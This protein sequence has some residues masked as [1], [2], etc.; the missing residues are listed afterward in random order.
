MNSSDRK[1][2][3]NHTWIWP[4]IFSPD[5]VIVYVV[6]ASFATNLFSKAT[7]IKSFD[8]LKKRSFFLSVAVNSQRLY[9]ATS[10]QFTVL[11]GNNNNL[12][13]CT[14]HYIIRKI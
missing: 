5:F 10:F 6:L 1:N 11:C 4:H 13:N 12:D 3:Q 2:S 9:G 8:D 14:V 7:G